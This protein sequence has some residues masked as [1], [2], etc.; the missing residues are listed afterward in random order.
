MS[1]T[2][3]HTKLYTIIFISLIVL[4][5]LTVWVSTVHLGGFGNL[6]IGLAIAIT[7]ASL[8]ALFFMHLKYDGKFDHYFYVAALFPIVLFFILVG[9]PLTDLAWMTM[10]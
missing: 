4:T 10:P 8:V 9:A 7:K 2:S 5:A 6:C 3:S 1:E